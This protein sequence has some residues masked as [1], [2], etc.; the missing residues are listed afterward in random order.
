MMGMSP[1]KIGGGDGT[2]IGEDGGVRV[3]S[4]VG[5]LLVE[6]FSAC[7]LALLCRVVTRPDSGRPPDADADAS[8]VRG[9]LRTRVVTRTIADGRTD[10]WTMAAGSSVTWTH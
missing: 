4:D 9:P 2:L 10:G 8:D 6:A 3:T 1:T 7:N 5:S